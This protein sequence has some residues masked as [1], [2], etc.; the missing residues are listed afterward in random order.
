MLIKNR[1]LLVSVVFPFPSKTLI[2]WITLFMSRVLVVVTVMLKH[3]WWNDAI[4]KD[5][6]TTLGNSINT[7]KKRKL[8]PRKTWT[9][10]YTKR[11][12]MTA[13]ECQW[14]VACASCS[15]RPLTS[16]LDL[17]QLQRWWIY[18]SQQVKGVWRA[19]LIQT[20][21]QNESEESSHKVLISVLRQNFSLGWLRDGLIGTHTC[22]LHHKLY[23]FSLQ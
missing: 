9:E 21:R 18:S 17:I 10:V 13:C 6:C 3:P 22:L 16:Q 5:K 15:L 7:S 14:I 19:L 8:G 2:K 20:H 1:L 12:P 11:T 4:Y 23:S